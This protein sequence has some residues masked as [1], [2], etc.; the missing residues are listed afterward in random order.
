MTGPAGTRKG[1]FSTTGFETRAGLA[2]VITIAATISKPDRERHILRAGIARPANSRSRPEAD[3]WLRSLDGDLYARL[4]R[5]AFVPLP[6]RLSLCPN[7][8][9]DS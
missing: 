4:P 5:R 9:V 1:V 2:L 3:Q 6:S 7:H 8:N